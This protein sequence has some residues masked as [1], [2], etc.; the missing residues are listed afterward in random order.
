MDKDAGGYRVSRL[1]G[2]YDVSG[3]DHR[4]LQD[5]SDC[6]ARHLEDSGFEFVSTPLIERTELFV[7]K[8]GGELTSKLYSFTDPG[9]NR[10]SLRP[11]FTSSVIR[12][13]VE[14]G[15][16]TGP[17]AR[18]YYAGPVFR[19][20]EEVA[21]RQFTQVGAEIVGA[22]GAAVDAE[23]VGLA[24]A[25]LE[26]AGLRGAVV[27]IGH[28]GVLNELIAGLGVSSR[29]KMMAISSAP[30]LK[31]ERTSVPRLMEDA[32][33]LGLLGAGPVGA[34]KQPS[35]RE[36]DADGE[37]I[38]DALA[39][40]MSSTLGRRSGRQ[41]VDRLM[42]K[43][44]EVDRPADL[45][46]AFELTSRLARVEGPPGPAIKEARTVA[47]SYGLEAASLDELDSLFEALDCNRTRS[48][49]VVLDMGLARGIAYYSGITFELTGPP[50]CGSVRLGGGGRYDGLV[51][52]LGGDDVPALG[53][54]FT[55]EHIVAA[56]NGK[57]HRR[58]RTRHLGA[59]LLRLAVPSDGALHEE[60]LHFLT[61]CGLGV[62]RSNHRTYTADLPALPG[63][64][65]A[66]PA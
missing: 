60:T 63:V 43:A 40:A 7:R 3:N 57:N 14:N 10:V 50:G 27:R 26:A 23:A 33:A 22:S 21:C 37:T 34:R 2:M 30:E 25:S 64:T 6:I 48:R 51:K 46:R 55:T 61:S 47:A 36:S 52:A 17:P 65:G 38:H 28:L 53:F 15:S 11:E 12:R 58:Q 54:A 35:R 20:D 44:H 29:A 1:P 49:D 18:W 16:P 13:F 32:R 41:I 19:Y 31:R 39:A 56:L 5:A 24:C 66:L 45:E 62:H 4:R 59:G 42:R 9:G 8:S